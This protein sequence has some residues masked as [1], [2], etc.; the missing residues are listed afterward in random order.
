ME[1]LDALLQDIQPTGRRKQTHARTQPAP[2]PVPAPAAAEE[3]DWDWDED[4]EP[5]PAA[6]AA[7]GGRQDPSPGEGEGEGEEDAAVLHMEEELRLFLA[8]VADPSVGARLQEHLCAQP[9]RAFIQYYLATPSLAEYTVTNELGRMDYSV[10]YA[11]HTSSDKTHILAMYESTKLSDVWRLANQSIYADAV[12]AV[13]ELYLSPELTVTL[14]SS[15]SRFALDLDRSRCTAAGTFSFSAPLSLDGDK[16]HFA[17]MDIL[18]EVDLLA[19]AVRHV[20]HA[21][22]LQIVFDADLRRV[23]RTGVELLRDQG[24][25]GAGKYKWFHTIGSIVDARSQLLSAQLKHTTGEIGE[26]GINVFII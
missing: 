2:A 5:P 3:E 22:V 12:F 13:Q 20:V 19:R 7:R 16:R 26:L 6:S 24:E 23:A 8:D 11:G 18:I 9:F 4:A 17:S 25:A 14:R 10:T 21:P 1:G 15:S